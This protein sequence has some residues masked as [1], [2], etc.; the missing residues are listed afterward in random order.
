L[1]AMKKPA[2]LNRFRVILLKLATPIVLIP[3]LVVAPAYVLTNPATTAMMAVDQAQVTDF[4]S[5][6]RLT[7]QHLYVINPPCEMIYIAGLLQRLFT[8]EPL[9]ASINYLTSGFAPVHIERVDAQTIRVTPEGGYTPPL[10]R[11]VDETSAMVNVYR[12]LEQNFY[13]SKDPMH[14]G[15]VVTLSEFK[16]QVTQMTE[17]GRIAQ[18]VFTFDHPLE[19]DRYVWLLWDEASS[20]YTTVQ[21]PMVG[22]K[23]VYR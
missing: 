5:D 20:T 9:P 14:V 17:D 16:V 13:N 23:A 6:P 4:G 8:D 11:M 21:M 18:A 12:A 10:G 3:F 1:A 15:Q 7:E 22:E 19:A 2:P